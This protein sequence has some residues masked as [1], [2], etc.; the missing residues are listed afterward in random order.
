MI[1]RFSDCELDTQRITLS[2]A[3]QIIRLRPKVYQLLEYLL[4]HHDRVISKDELCMAIW[5]DQFIQDTTLGST[6]R[7]VRNAVGDTGSSQAV[8]QTRHGH[9]YRLIADVEILS[10]A[11]REAV[12]PV[13]ADLFPDPLTPL[14]KDPL[15]TKVDHATI[16]LVDDEMTIVKRL[17]ALLI[18]RNFRVLTAFNGHDG[19]EQA[20][21]ERPDLILLDVMMPDING[22]EVCQRLKEDDETQLIPVVLMTALS[23][24]EDRIKGLEAGADDFLTKPVHRDELLARIQSSLRLKHTIDQKVEALQQQSR[25]SVT[26]AVYGPLYLT[27]T[28]QGEML[29]VDLAAPGSVVPPG[30]V[31]LANH[32][33]DDID[34]ELTRILTLGVDPAARC[35]VEAPLT[36]TPAVEDAYT[37]LQRLGNLIFSYLL[38]SPIRQRLAEAEPADL[39]LRQKDNTLSIPWELTFDGKAFWADKFRIGRQML[40]DQPPS[41]TGLKSGLATTP[42]MLIIADPSAHRTSGM[43]EAEQLCDALGVCDNLEISVVGGKQL[44]K[45]DLL[46]SLGEYDLVHYMGQAVFDVSQP[47][48]SG[49]VLHDNVLTVSELS[50]LTHPPQL[51]FAN[52]CPAPSTLVTPPEMMG[53]GHPFDIGRAFLQ[54]GTAHYISQFCASH[55][56]GNIAF[57]ADF[58]R[59]LLQGNSVGTALAMARHRARQS[60]SPHDIF[61]VSFVHYGDPTFQLPNITPRL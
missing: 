52:A 40:S 57:A 16:L 55:H 24:V 3:G 23:D 5:P 56:P 54:S 21:R 11:D 17:E 29:T 18:P 51:I 47:S 45:I 33:I 44:R 46:L 13:S 39:F 14:A 37:A 6:V 25:V 32:L 27:V 41:A 31:Q 1:Y 8:I 28:R 10:E 38:P 61:W 53:A 34:H 19:L 2:R 50:Q 43:A 26:Q 60:A 35:P 58:Y 42:R 22:F 36:A 49:W 59:H 48:R 15:N 7:A 20:K 12:E 30:D 4:M 9:G